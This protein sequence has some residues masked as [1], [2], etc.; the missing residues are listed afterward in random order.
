MIGGFDGYN[1]MTAQVAGERLLAAR[2]QLDA[3]CEQ[4]KEMGVAMT[5]LI[6]EGLPVEHILAE[7]D[8]RK[9][10]LIVIGSHGL[11][12]LQRV[13]VG[14]TTLAVLKRA[15]CPVVVVPSANRSG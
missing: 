6:Y 14:S 8:K 3:L 1:P 11:G 4:H 15:T 12:V 5:A 9:A 2:T 7:A 10:D 13:F